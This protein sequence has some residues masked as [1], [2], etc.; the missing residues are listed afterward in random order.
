VKPEVHIYKSGEDFLVC[1]ATGFPPPRLTWYKDNKDV[2]NNIMN[3]EK[4]LTIKK[5][6]GN[7]T[8]VASN[9]AGTATKSFIYTG[10]TACVFMK[11][12]AK[13]PLFAEII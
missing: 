3:K 6:G 12:N 5:S 4:S 7:L 1:N 2:E 10:K 11:Y 13:I 9:S 8:C